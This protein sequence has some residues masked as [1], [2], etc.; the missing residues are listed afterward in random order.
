ML[1]SRATYKWVHSPYSQWHLALQ[2]PPYSIVAT[3]KFGGRGIM[4]W[5]R[6]SWFGQGPLVPV[7]GNLNAT[8]YNDILYDSVLPTLWQQFGE[9]LFLFQQDNNPMHKA[10]SIQKWFVEIGVEELDWPAQSP[11]LNPI[12]H[13]WDEL[14]R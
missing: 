13:L 1:L 8:A 4:V 10:R 12:E 14:E 3:V 11:E 9:G 5:G 7:K 2:L 6:F